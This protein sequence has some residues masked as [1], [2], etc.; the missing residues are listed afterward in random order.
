MQSNVL[1]TPRLRFGEIDL[2]Y[3]IWLLLENDKVIP[4]WR[5]DLLKN[6]NFCQVLVMRI[7]DKHLQ[8][9]R[10]AD[11]YSCEMRYYIADLEFGSSSGCI[12]ERVSNDY[13]VL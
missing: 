10:C 12:W 5:P 11:W 6:T 7:L 9:F 1:S 2:N 8:L 13:A 3:R 4:G